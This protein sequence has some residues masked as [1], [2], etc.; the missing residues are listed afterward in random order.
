MNE[1]KPNSAVLDDMLNPLPRFTFNTTVLRN[2]KISL[3]TRKRVACYVAE[4][5]KSGGNRNIV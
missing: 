5:D 4:E 2:R 1:N 3:E